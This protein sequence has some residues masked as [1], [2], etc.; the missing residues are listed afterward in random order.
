[1]SRPFS[2]RYKN[3][4]IDFAVDFMYRKYETENVCGHSL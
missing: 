1:M 2:Q 3:D 4:C